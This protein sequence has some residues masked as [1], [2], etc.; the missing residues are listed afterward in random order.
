[1][2]VPVF[3]GDLFSLPIAGSVGGEIPFGFAQF[4]RDRNIFVADFG[5]KPGLNAYCFRTAV[6]LPSENQGLLDTLAQAI[7]A[8]S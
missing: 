7:S 6:G 1:M 5:L 8:L 2:V 3:R 4:L